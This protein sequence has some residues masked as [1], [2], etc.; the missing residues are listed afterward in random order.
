MIRLDMDQLT[1]LIGSIERHLRRIPLS[2]VNLGIRSLVEDDEDMYE[3]EVA[4]ADNLLSDVKI[5]NYLTTGYLG[6]QRTAS[7]FTLINYAI[8]R[9]NMNGW[10]RGRQMVKIKC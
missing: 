3:N 4:P 7:S 2:M 9:K 10:M 1:M 6:N 5:C 8:E